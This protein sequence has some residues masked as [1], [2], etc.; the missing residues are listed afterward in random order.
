MD[1]RQL[2][3]FVEVAKQKSF[4]KA[5]QALRISQPSISKMIKGLED[6]L[7]V[8]LLDRSDREVELTDAGLVAYEQAIHIL[9]SIR[10]LASSIDELVHVQKGKVR[11][12][13]L[14]TIGALL[15][16]HII[17]GFKKEYPQIEIQ[18]TEYS[19]KHIEI[20]VEK[21]TVDFGVTVL[22]IDTEKFETVSLL[23][24][25]LVAI[26]D[27][28]HKFVGRD[29]IALSELRNE[30]FILFSEE[31]VLHD[32]VRRACIQSGFEPK[33]AYMAS[34]WDLVCEMVTT[35]L[36]ISVIPRS[37]ASRLNNPKVH[38]IALSAPH[39]AWELALIY[40]RNKYLSYATKEFM[41]Y[42]REHLPR[43]ST[44]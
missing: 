23:S 31:F 15:F 7:G 3:Y 37:M 30:A 22:P 21:G 43:K 16:P 24:E 26:V 1:I 8:T 9:Q 10:H 5:S 11:M 17:A 28:D 25:D 18:M 40:R 20:Q 35:Q 42:I 13:L 14:P 29:S 27:G 6:E 38:I 19:A 2:Q 33:I 12:G 36:G 39:I 41:K 32:V 4:T 34:L 44:L